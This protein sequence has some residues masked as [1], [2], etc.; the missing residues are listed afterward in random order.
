MRRWGSEILPRLVAME[1]GR[2]LEG[3]EWM[4][5]LAA[6]AERLEEDE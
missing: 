5:V 3:C 1:G 4:V 2:C 6:A